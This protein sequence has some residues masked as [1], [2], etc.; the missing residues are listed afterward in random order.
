MYFANIPPQ[1]KLRR[2]NSPKGLILQELVNGRD[3]CKNYTVCANISIIDG[4][5]SALH[6]TGKKFSSDTIFD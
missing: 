3:Y 1:H 2:I 5:Y 6:P 4:D